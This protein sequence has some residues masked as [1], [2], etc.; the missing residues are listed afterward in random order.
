M[1]KVILGFCFVFVI[2]ALLLT[3][4]PSSGVS[5]AQSGD[6]VNPSETS[7]AID[8]SLEQLVSQ[9]DLIAIGNCR[10]SRSLW[11]DRNLVTLANISVAETLKGNPAENITVILPGGVDANRK[12]PIAMSVA[13]APRITPG[14]DVVLFLTSE[15]EVGGSYSI[16]GFS[17]GK[18]SIG[19]DEE[20]R[21][22]VSRDLTNV[23]LQS[24]A[25]LRRGTQFV[26]ALE[27][28]KSQIR[29]HLQKD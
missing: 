12:F 27:S 14:E 5:T 19:K 29:R 24:K 15:S 9:S 22:V 21:E 28:L 26:T 2:S 17:Q 10:Q 7:V 23:K 4:W 20:G 11:I 8:L 25:G 13:G 6:S 16:T 18:F 1:K 3:K